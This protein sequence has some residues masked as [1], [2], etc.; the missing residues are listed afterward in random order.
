VTVEEGLDPVL[1]APEPTPREV[2][3]TVISVDD[4]LVE[5]PGMFEGRLPARLQDQAPN[6]VETPEGHQVWEFDGN[7]YSR[8]GNTVYP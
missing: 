8:V 6:V 4:Q 2:R 7:R 1:F 5:P 3:Y